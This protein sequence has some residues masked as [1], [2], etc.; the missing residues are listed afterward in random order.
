VHALE[1]KGDKN[2]KAIHVAT[3]HGWSDHRIFLESAV[4]EWLSTLN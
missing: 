2:I 3:D 4:L 1:A